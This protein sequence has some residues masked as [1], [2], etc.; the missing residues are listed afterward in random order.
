MDAGL[1]L[2]EP[3]EPGSAWDVVRHV[4]YERHQGLME[5]L[6]R[7]STSG[8]FR[9][10]R[11]MVRGLSDAIAGQWG[12][13]RLREYLSYLYTRPEWVRYDRLRTEGRK[14]SVKYRAR[15]RWRQAKRR[16][17]ERFERGLDE[18]EVRRALRGRVEVTVES[19]VQ[20]LGFE[21][22]LSIR[23]AMGSCLARLGWV[24]HQRKDGTRF[25]RRKASSR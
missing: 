20:G 5:A 14:H 21:D 6:G 19:L 4:F 10:L 3:E 23:T 24:R 16:A 2:L 15:E 18:G 7:A 12:E 11:G 22:S 8:D 17:A 25:Y 13:A 9:A 1:V